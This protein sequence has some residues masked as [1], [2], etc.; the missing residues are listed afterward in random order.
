MTLST[1]TIRPRRMNRVKTVDTDQRDA[2]S[3][4]V[5]AREEK[6]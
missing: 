2:G 5:H 1:G 4:R 6:G 3:Q